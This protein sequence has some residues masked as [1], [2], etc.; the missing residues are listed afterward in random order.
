M[1]VAIIG[2]LEAKKLLRDDYDSNWCRPPFMPGRLQRAWEDDM[3][4]PLEKCFMA[5]PMAI[6]QGE[7]PSPGAE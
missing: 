6:W 2:G 1:I 5:S 3:D 4:F 7:Q